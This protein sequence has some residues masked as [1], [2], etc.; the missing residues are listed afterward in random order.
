[1]KLV[2]RFSFVLAMLAFLAACGGGGDDDSSSGSPSVSDSELTSGSFKYSQTTGKVYQSPGYDT[3]GHYCTDADRYFESDNVMV[4]SGGTHSD[5]DYKVAAT[6]TERNFDSV[7]A[8]FGMD[9][10]EYAAMKRTVSFQDLDFVV[11]PLS[12][13]LVEDPDTGTKTRVL[14]SDLSPYF[15]DKMPEGSEDWRNE[16]NETPADGGLSYSTQHMLFIVDTLNAEADQSRVLPV[17]V[18][19][20]ETWAGIDFDTSIGTNPESTAEVLSKAVI[21]DKVQ[22]CLTPDLGQAEGSIQGLQTGMDMSEQVFAHELVHHVQHQLNYFMLRWFSE[23]QA[24]A[25][26]GQRTASGGAD[27]NP[28]DIVTWEDEN[29]ID[30]R[31]AYEQYGLAYKALAKHNSTDSIIAW[32]RATNKSRTGMFPDLEDMPI[33]MFDQYF[34]DET[35]APMTHA[36][37]R[38]RYLELAK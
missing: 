34:V 25:I 22:V 9:K 11:N 1:M 38:D 4:F 36:Q 33:A 10:A 15:A 35:G 13:I 21:H 3:L 30:T 17:L 29:N 26:A 32:L 7:L 6:L 37:F 19:M 5:R 16:F 20:L 12:D 31:Q 28:V 2:V 8:G 24:V 14:A 23:G 18:E 27:F